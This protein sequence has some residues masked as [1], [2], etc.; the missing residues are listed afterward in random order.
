VEELRRLGC[1]RIGAYVTALPP[2]PADA[3]TL[4]MHWQSLLAAG[5]TDLH[6]Y[7]AGLASDR[8][9]A[10]VRTALASLRPLKEQ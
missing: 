5:A 2:V 3:D 7:H 4:A 9:L 10:A 1:E 8:R 6:I